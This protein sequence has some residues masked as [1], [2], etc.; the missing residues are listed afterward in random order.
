MTAKRL[1]DEST[2]EGRKIWADVDK[3]VSYLPRYLTHTRA[4]Y[5][6]RINPPCIC[7]AAKASREAGDRPSGGGRV[8]PINHRDYRVETSFACAWVRVRSGVI[9]DC[10][11]I[12]RR[13]FMG[14]PFEELR[15]VAVEVVDI[16]DE[17][18]RDGE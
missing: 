17:E 5:E 14:R 7:G 18:A 11:P 16:T 8:T 2:P 15:K 6:Q 3:A 9:V 10:A 4:C 12:Y 1:R 13:K